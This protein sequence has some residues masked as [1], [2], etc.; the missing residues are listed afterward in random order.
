MMWFA[1]VSVLLSFTGG[2]VGTAQAS[3]PGVIRAVPAT[4]PI[5][6]SVAKTSGTVIVEV[7]INADGSVR[8]ASAVQGHEVFR[9]AAERSARQWVFSRI[10]DQHLART[11]RI[12]YSFKMIAATSNA[13]ELVPVF[14]PPFSL[15]IR[16]TTP[17]YDYSKSVDPPNKYP[18]RRKPRR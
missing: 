9:V 5:L 10:E 4:Y 6:A 3:E 12:T 15:E 1:L 2:T 16:G 11:V 8:E 17:A 14:M 18:T 13:E 7:T